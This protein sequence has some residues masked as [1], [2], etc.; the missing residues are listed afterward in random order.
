MIA[1][2]VLCLETELQ[3]DEKQFREIKG[4][5]SF[6]NFLIQKPNVKIGIATGGWEKSAILK[7]KSIGINACE[8]AFSNSNHFK[9]REEILSSTIQ[10]INQKCENKIEQTIYFGDGN[11]DFLTCK[12]L[13]IEFIGI[14]NTNKLKDFGAKTIFNDFEHYELIYKNLKIK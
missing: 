4:A 8:F 5:S 9:T 11:W 14:D 1:E 10:K 3:T 12:K 13:G 2:F 7:L 6:I